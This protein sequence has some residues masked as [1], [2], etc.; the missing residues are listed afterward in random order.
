M[1]PRDVDDPTGDA[2]RTALRARLR[3]VRHELDGLVGTRI[4][5]PLSAAQEQRYREL[6]AQESKLLLEL[7]PD[8]S[9]RPT[10]T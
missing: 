9:D 7:A 1:S 5:A 6:C 2:E 3:A 8:I 10:P 4:Q